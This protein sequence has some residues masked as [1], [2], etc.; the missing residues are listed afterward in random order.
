MN[1]SDERFFNYPP[2]TRQA[3]A[4]FQRTR[5][6]AL[7]DPILHAVLHKYLPEGT[8]ADAVSS[9]AP[10]ATLGSFGFESLT[11]VEI[12]LDL[13]DAFGITF[14]DEEL[15]G[16]TTLEEARGVLARKVAALRQP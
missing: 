15:R 12:I 3:I 11:M 8:P 10:E 1:T 7:I 5:D 6:P 13:Q 2:A 16:M 14:G 9:H 4:E